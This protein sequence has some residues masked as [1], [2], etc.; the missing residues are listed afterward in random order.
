MNETWNGRK[1]SGVP[2]YTST[3]RGIQINL[4]SY[5]HPLVLVQRISVDDNGVY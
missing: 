1:K 2:G 3:T 5:H 4:S